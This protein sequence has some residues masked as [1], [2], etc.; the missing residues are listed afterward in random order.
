MAHFHPHSPIYKIGAAQK[1]DEG[2]S[3]SPQAS[4]EGLVS[5]QIVKRAKWIS[6]C[7]AHAGRVACE[8]LP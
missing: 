7:L 6:K 3:H 1:T 4:M 5:A 8:T 2:F